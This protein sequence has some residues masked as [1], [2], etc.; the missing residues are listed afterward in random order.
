MNLDIEVD[1]GVSESE[2]QQDAIPCGPYFLF[3]QSSFILWG[4]CRGERVKQREQ[5]I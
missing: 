3:I 4:S 5:G 2:Q 1:D